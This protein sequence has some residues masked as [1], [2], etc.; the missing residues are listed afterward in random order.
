[1]LALGVATAIAHPRVPLRRA[2]AALGAATLAGLLA[3]VV[4]VGTI[5][6]AWSWP[7]HELATAGGWTTAGIGALAAVAL[8]N[9]P[10]AALLS[11]SAPP[12]ARAL[13]VGLN[14]GPNLAVTGSLSAFLWWRSA[15]GAGASPSA[16]RYS[17]L[18]LATAPAAGLA[19]LAAL[20]L[21]VPNGF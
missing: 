17:L 5:A 18:G 13:L 9:L 21:L 3:I 8:N 19:A 15:R 11:A 1:V 14:L 12:H 10:A 2:Y 4:A 16:L 20:H 7:G 6:R